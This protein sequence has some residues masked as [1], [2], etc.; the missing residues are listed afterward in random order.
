M[1]PKEIQADLNRI[2]NEQILILDK[3]PGDLDICHVAE[4]D[5]YLPTAT[6]TKIKEILAAVSRTSGY[7]YQLEMRYVNHNGLTTFSYNFGDGAF[8]I[9]VAC[10]NCRTEKP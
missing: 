5:V 6:Q 7:N 1:T 2:F 10:T 4:K 9:V 8:Q 3:L